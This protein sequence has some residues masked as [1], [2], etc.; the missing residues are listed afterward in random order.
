MALV[1]L[2]MMLLLLVLVLLLLLLLQRGVVPTRNRTMINVGGTAPA[3]LAPHAPAPQ[4]NTAAQDPAPGSL[5]QPR[6]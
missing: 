5:L 6:F 3:R 2:V 1:V 4:R